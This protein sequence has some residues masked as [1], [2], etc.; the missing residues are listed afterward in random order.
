MHPPGCVSV[1]L[2]DGGDAVVVPGQLE[3]AHHAAVE[4]DKQVSDEQAALVIIVFNKLFS[5]HVKELSM[6]QV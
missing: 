6:M 1:I 3:L 2:P 4:A 5:E